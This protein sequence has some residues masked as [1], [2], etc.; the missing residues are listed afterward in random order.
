MALLWKQHKVASYHRYRACS[1]FPNINLYIHYNNILLEF[2]FPSTN[3]T[4]H[5][6]IIILDR[7]DDFIAFL[8]R[9]TVMVIPILM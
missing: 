1:H 2:S 3:N 8:F 7:Q 4:S 5:A 6:T 9:S